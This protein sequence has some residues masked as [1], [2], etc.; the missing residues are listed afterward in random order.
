MK[1]K[2]IFVIFVLL[3]SVSLVKAQSADTPKFD[4]P[5]WRG[6]NR[7][8][9]SKETGLLKS[10]PE[11][12]PEIAWKS[13]IG[14]GYSGL[15]I[16]QGRI[17][18]MDSNGKEEFVVC[19]DQTTGKEMWRTKTDAS[20]QS[21]QGDGHRSTPTVDGNWVY[22]IGANGILM[23]VSS[24]DGKKVW[25]H[26]LRTEFESEIPRWGTSTSP[27]VEKDLLLV[28]VGGKTGYALMAFNKK[29]G[30][31]AWKAHTDKQG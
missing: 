31:I 9:I 8:G 2:N 3:L 23:A 5:Q 7:D 11:S 18:T 26:D 28:N 29:D 17:Y 24:A 15:S 21:D 27:I 22:S 14:A 6:P 20:F 16:S 10:W 13:P 25:S 4:W 19:L 12:G 1:G 30:S